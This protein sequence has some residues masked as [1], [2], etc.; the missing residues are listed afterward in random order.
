MIEA[1]EWDMR[2][3]E[4]VRRWRELKARSLPAIAI[5]GELVFQAM[6]PL[7]EEL[8]EEILKRRTD[9]AKVTDHED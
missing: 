1:H 6:I 5:N 2:T 3:H 8:I 4:G 7:R 9:P